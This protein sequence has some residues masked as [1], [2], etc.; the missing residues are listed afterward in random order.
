MLNIVTEKRTIKR[1]QKM[2]ESEL[3]GVLQK[4]EQ[5]QIGYPG[6]HFEGRVFFDDGLWFSTQQLMGGDVKIPRYWNAFGLG[7]KETIHQTIVVE[8]NPPIEGVTRKVSGLF[9]IEK[10][11]GKYYLLHRGRIGGGRRGIGKDSFKAW[12]RGSWVKVSEPEGVVSEA[13]LLGPLGQ[14]GLVTPIKTFVREVDNFKKEVASG[15]SSREPPFVVKNFFSAEG[16]GRRRGK[17]KSRIDYE[18]YHGLVVNELEKWLKT[19]GMA[20]NKRIFN[21]KFIDLGLLVSGC[22]NHLF[23]VKSSAE[24][25]VVY[26][27][28]GQLFLHSMQSK[29]NGKVHKTL[30]LPFDQCSKKLIKTLNKLGINVLDYSIERDIIIFRTYHQI[31]R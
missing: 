23:E 5:L 21:N 1:C 16:F 8:V 22:I 17:R 27:G 6:G 20:R 18:S 12:Y 10:E 14:S 3:R 9:A 15:L 11:T 26:A 19:Q 13:I 29:G 7:K 31:L 24:S 30:V 2:L 25:Q 28:V 4:Y